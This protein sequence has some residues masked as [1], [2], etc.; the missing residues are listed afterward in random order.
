MNREEIYK[1]LSRIL[2]SE[3][4]SEFVLVVKSRPYGLFHTYVPFDDIAFSGD[5]RFTV[6]ATNGKTESIRYRDVVRIE[7]FESVGD[8]A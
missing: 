7:G 5:E 8:E 3:G 2:R 1:E 6:I 4:F